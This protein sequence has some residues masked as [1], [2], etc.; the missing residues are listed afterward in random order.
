MKND[1][2]NIFEYINYR[3]YLEDFYVWKK[4]LEPGFSHA[5]ICHRLYQP[6]SKTY[7]NNVFKGRKPVTATFVDRFIDLLDLSSFFGV[8]IRMRP[9]SSE[10]ARRF[11][12]TCP[13]VKTA[14]FLCASRALLEKW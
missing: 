13:E 3:N 1:K 10:T 11:P 7:F 8:R 5:Y 12:A 6:H 9:P 2:P 14:S 4:A